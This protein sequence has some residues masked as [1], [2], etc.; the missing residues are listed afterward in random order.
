[1]LGLSIFGIFAPKTIPK[2]NTQFK[3]LLLDSYSIE[4]RCM[5]ATIIL[6]LIAQC[7]SIE[8]RE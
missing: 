1:M 7:Y 3:K 2:N 6:Q 4:I 5:N 8:R